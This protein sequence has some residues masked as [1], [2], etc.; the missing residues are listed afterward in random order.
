MSFRSNNYSGILERIHRKQTRL[1]LFLKFCF[2]FKLEYI[3]S[4]I[5]CIIDSPLLWIIIISF[6]NNSVTTSEIS[7]NCHNWFIIWIM[8]CTSNTTGR[9]ARKVG[10]WVIFQF[11]FVLSFCRSNIILKLQVICLNDSALNFIV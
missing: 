9:L 3:C 8:N 11:T 10:V 2:V 1:V 4:I 7:L 6:K 5:I